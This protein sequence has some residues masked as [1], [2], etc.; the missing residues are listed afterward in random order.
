MSCE[1]GAVIDWGEESGSVLVALA[2]AR[3]IPGGTDPERFIQADGS[4]RAAADH[5][6]KTTFDRL[7]GLGILISGLGGSSAPGGGVL[8][9]TDELCQQEFELILFS[10][11]RLDRG[12]LPAQSLTERGPESGHSS[13]RG[14]RKRQ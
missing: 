13:P 3:S 10:A 9:L 5:I 6:I 14:V 4:T 1:T 2:T 12:F 7:C 8:A 11:V